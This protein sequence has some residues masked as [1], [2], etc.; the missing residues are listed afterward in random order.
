MSAIVRVRRTRRAVVA[1]AALG[2]AAVCGSVVVTAPAASAAEPSHTS[3]T[4]QAPASVGAAGG[5]V[6]FT[7]TITN[8][9]PDATDYNLEL[10]T[11]TGAATQA[12][13][14][15][16]D[17]ENPADGTWTSVPLT[18][19]RGVDD[20]QYEGTVP[21]LSVPA[22]RTRKVD[23]RIGAPMGLPHNGSR[24]GG[25][26]SI[27]LH[28]AV[29][30]PL[31]FH[32]RVEAE[33]TS[34]IKVATIGSSLAHVPATAVAGGAPIEF[35]AVLDNPTPSDYTDLGKVLFVDEH[36]T[37]QVRTADGAG[38]PWRTCPA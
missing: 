31:H 29:V 27:A 7:E 21:G 24:D 38:G 33:A 16:I 32:D 17:Y 28:S 4:V 15:V 10:K 23:L 19:H 26:P 3:L 11:V 6:A 36:A 35:D 18:M 13:A 30:T 25:F 12:N 9:G 8:A 34:T 22:G 14:I 1:A 37:V 20:V 5:P 2:A